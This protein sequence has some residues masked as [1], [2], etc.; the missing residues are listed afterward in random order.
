MVRAQLLKSTVTLACAVVALASLAAAAAAGPDDKPAPTGVW[1]QA[2]GEAKIEFI[3]KEVLKIYPHGDNE[4]VIVV[5]RYTID[6]DELVE[7]KI[8]EIDGTAKD[9]VKEIVPIGTKFSFKWRLKDAT[10]TLEDLEGDEI[11]K[12]LEGKYE[13]KN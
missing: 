12:H 10:A 1:M 6:K 13:K 9:K 8:T 3:D 11:P 2:E 4:S 7:A 5:C